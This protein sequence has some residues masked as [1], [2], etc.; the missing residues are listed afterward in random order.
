M[1]AYSRTSDAEMAVF[2]SGPGGVRPGSALAALRTLE[3]AVHF[4]RVR[5]FRGPI[6]TRTVILGEFV[7]AA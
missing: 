5:A 1:L 4:L 2:S 6:R 7:H 3:N